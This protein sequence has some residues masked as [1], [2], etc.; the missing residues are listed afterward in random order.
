METL[1]ILIVFCLLLYKIFNLNEGFNIQ[2]GVP[3]GFSNVLSP[4]PRCLNSNNC[5]PGYYLRS[6]LYNNMCSPPRFGEL[7]KYPISLQNCCL[8]KL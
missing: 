6:E 5:F 2:T 1:L 3:R 7:T 4:Y 8:R